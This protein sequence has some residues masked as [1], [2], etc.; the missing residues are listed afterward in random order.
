MGWSFH[1]TI[2]TRADMTA[3]LSASLKSAGHTILRASTV[4]NH[5]WA[6]IEHRDGKRH[7]FL[8][9]MQG[10]GQEGWGYKGMDES[11]G[12]YHFDCPLGLL[13]LVPPPCG[14]YAA[15]WRDK[16]REHHAAKRGRPTPLPGATV[17]YGGHRYTLD[18]PC[19][20][21]KGWHVTR[22]DGMQ[23]RMKAYQL[24]HAKHVAGST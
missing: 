6:A 24:A 10:G 17:E 12:P 5:W 9:L 7:I 3:Y 21:R 23:F 4:G 11:A 1:S 2:R 16:V 18:R 22:A 20:P 8:A 15:G 13:E 14:P 19:G